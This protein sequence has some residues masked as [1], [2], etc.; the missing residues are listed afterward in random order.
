M[1][2]PPSNA[3]LRRACRAESY[4]RDTRQTHRPN[5][6]GPTAAPEAL[7]APEAR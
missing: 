2:M 3:A 6:A 4:G 5:D 1:P 7:H